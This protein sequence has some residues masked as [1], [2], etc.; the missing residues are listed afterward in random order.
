[1]KRKKRPCKNCHTP[2]VHDKYNYHKQEYCYKPECR[3]TAAKEKKKKYRQKRKWDLE[4]RAQEV[5]RVQQWRLE[6]PKYSRKTKVLKT[7]GVAPSLADNKDSTLTSEKIDVLRDLVIRQELIIVGMASQFV[8]VIPEN[9][10]SFILNC[11]NTGRH[12]TH[13]SDSADNLFS[14]SKSLLDEKII[15]IQKKSLHDHAL[16]DLAQGGNKRYGTS[17]FHNH[18]E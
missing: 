1:M 4:Y 3:K 13:F 12:F 15:K 5:I 6:N 11:C 18:L 17:L 2:F 14:S 8:G 7:L 10:E 9:V 16:R